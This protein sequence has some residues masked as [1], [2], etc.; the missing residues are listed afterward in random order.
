MGILAE[1]ILKYEIQSTSFSKEKLPEV[2]L[3]FTGS[4]AIYFI[5]Y[6][7]ILFM[8]WLKHI[9]FS[10]KFYKFINLS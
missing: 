6:W 10:N 8:L 7:T 3:L 4:L 2:Y 9:F 5:H 1:F